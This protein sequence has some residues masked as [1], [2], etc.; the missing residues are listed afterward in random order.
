MTSQILLLNYFV[1]GAH[2][3]VNLVSQNKHDVKKDLRF[4]K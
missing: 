1:D 2:Q 3:V 4:Y